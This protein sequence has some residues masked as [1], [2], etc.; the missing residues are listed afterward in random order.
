M[1]KAQIITQR[2]GLIV[3]R[4][5][6]KKGIHTTVWADGIITC[7]CLGHRFTGDCK[8]S[9]SMRMLGDFVAA[10]GEVAA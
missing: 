4:I 3:A 2:D 10:R 5:Q 7:T 9:Q 1:V 6:G 8:H